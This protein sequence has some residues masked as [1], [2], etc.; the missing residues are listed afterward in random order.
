MKIE[1]SSSSH[2]HLHASIKAHAE[3]CC[4]V[5]CSLL[6]FLRQLPGGYAGAGG[7]DVPPHLEEELVR[8]VLA[9]QLDGV[10]NTIQREARSVTVNDVHVLLLR[11]H[12]VM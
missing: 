7:Q 6:F 3:P 10:A 8:L 5:K 11:V 4:P 2:R 9:E 12:S 1:T